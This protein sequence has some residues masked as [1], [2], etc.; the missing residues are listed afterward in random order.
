MVKVN[1]KSNNLFWYE[2]VIDDAPRF[3]PGKSLYNLIDLITDP[4]NLNYIITDDIEGRMVAYCQENMRSAIKIS[5]M[6][7]QLKTVVQFDWGDFYMYKN[8]PE[9]W[10]FPEDLPTRHAEYRQLIKDTDV[11]VRAVDDQYM[12]IYTRDENLVKLI[13]D[14]YIT[15]S[16]KFAPLES[17]LFP[18]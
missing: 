13:S 18:C 14:H 6:L 8:Y 15:E 17:Y 12:Y 9:N 5:E 3:L 4:G 1:K 2:I 7:P 16:I 10:E 11:T